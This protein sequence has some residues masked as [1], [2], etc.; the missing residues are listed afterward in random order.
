VELARAEFGGDDFGEFFDLHERVFAR[1]LHSE[2]DLEV[3][4]TA[5]D[6][7]LQP[8]SAAPAGH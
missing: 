3:S 5:T 7:S 8:V 4:A 2:D 6:L 1:I